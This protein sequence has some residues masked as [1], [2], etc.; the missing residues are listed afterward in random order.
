MDHY[1]YKSWLRHCVGAR[2]KEA[3]C[4]VGQQCCEDKEVGVRA[5]M[6]I[7]V[8]DKG[9]KKNHFFYVPS[10]RVLEINKIIS[11]RCYS[12]KK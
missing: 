3:H 4:E 5:L 1:S 11:V 9:K 6:N 7:E 10:V 2:T 8:E 12:N